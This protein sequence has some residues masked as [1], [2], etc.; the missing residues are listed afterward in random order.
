MTRLLAIISLP[1]AMSLLSLALCV[2][3]L[4]AVGILIFGAFEELFKKIGVRV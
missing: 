1:L 4:W 2:I 3:F